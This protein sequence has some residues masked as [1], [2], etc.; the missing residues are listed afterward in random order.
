MDLQLPNISWS[1]RRPRTI[2]SSTINEYNLHALQMHNHLLEFDIRPTRGKG[3][4][5]SSTS[6]QSK[7]TIH[8]FVL[9]LDSYSL[10]LLTHLSLAAQSV[11]S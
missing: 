8:Y 10:P 2:D 1:T 3:M 11:L 7:C 9:F 5:S 6:R 4:Y